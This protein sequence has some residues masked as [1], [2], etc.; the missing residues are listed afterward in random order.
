MTKFNEEMLN[1]LEGICEDVDGVFSLLDLVSDT[2]NDYVDIAA[3][4]AIRNLVCD[5][6]DQLLMF[7]HDLQE[8]Q[9]K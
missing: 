4:C 1:K 5:A 6:R 9:Q 2:A 7:I 3:V 8:T